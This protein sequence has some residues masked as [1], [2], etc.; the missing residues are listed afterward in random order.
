MAITGLL[1]GARRGEERNVFAF[2]RGRRTDRP[3]IDPCRADGDEEASVEPRVACRECPVAGFVIRFHRMSILQTSAVNL[4][5]FGHCHPTLATFNHADW[6]ADPR[7]A[8]DD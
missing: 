1:S 4:A 8:K 2:R 7:S 5:V 3:A 6:L